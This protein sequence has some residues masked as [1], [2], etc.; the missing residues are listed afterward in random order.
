[1]SD[2]LDDVFD[3][4]P[5]M[6]AEDWRAMDKAKGDSDKEYD[7]E[8]DCYL[9][10]LSRGLVVMTPRWNMIQ[11]D[12]D[13]DKAFEEFQRRLDA[14]QGICTED[15]PY[16]PDLFLG[17]IDQVVV[18]S[19]S[20]LPHRHVYLSFPDIK[21]TDVGFT[22]QERILLQAALNDDPLRVFLNTMRMLSGI[23]NP[24]RLFRKP[25]VETR[26]GLLYEIGEKDDNCYLSACVADARAR[27]HGF[28]HA[29]QLV[30]WLEEC[31]KPFR[32]RS[33]QRAL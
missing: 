17:H 33:L 5:G 32:Q 8:E 29:E 14:F 28:Q 9:T 21:V 23:E 2:E 19:S 31:K 12:L 24:S 25:D 1:M 6:S 30:R 4:I 15:S 22:D 7:W 3:E 26:N 11:L 20:G 18:P 27:G 10:A 16:R 13:S